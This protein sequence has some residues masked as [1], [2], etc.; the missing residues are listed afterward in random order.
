QAF[1]VLTF[2]TLDDCAVP[3]M[4]WSFGVLCDAQAAG[5]VEALAAHGRRVLRVHL[6]GPRTAALAALAGVL[7]RAHASRTTA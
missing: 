1:L 7:E 3:G 6:E 2:E 5:D 4:P